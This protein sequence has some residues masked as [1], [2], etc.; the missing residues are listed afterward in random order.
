MNKPTLER[1]RRFSLSL[2]D[3]GCLVTVFG[4]FFSLGPLYVHGEN[5]EIMNS[6][7]VAILSKKLTKTSSV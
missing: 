7:G 6:Q 2:I 4:C 3:K 5:G 1:S